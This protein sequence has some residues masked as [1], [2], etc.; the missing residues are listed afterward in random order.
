MNMGFSYVIG[1]LVGILVSALLVKAFIRKFHT[2][3]EKKDRYDERQHMLIGKGYKY[4]FYGIMVYDGLYAVVGS[5]LDS[6]LMVPGIAAFVNIAVGLAVF[7]TYCIWNGAYFALNF[8]ARRYL[9]LLVFLA[10]INY[11]AGFFYLK[12][13]VPMVE[14]GL[15]TTSS[16]NFICAALMTFILLVALV[17][18]LTPVKGEEDEDLDEE[19]MEMLEGEM[20]GGNAVDESNPNDKEQEAH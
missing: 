13:G 1:L 8:N 12:V 10:V 5:W 17:R 19:E 6:S 14:D 11:I 16:A 2:N 20:L 15:L 7:A 3:G 18:K 4:G 9:I